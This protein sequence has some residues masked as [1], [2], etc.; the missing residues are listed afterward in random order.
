MKSCG[1]AAEEERE[2]KTDEKGG[3][4]GTEPKTRQRRGR[5]R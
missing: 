5:E 2:R 1:E 4:R 3:M